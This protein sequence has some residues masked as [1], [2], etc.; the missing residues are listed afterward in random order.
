MES[1]DPMAEARRYVANAEEII[2]KSVY[3]PATKLYRDNIIIGIWLP[4]H[5]AVVKIGFGEIVLSTTG[6]DPNC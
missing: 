2:K 3:D 4:Q 5:G 6:R 1:K